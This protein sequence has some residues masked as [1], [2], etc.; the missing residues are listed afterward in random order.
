M[1]YIPGSHKFDQ[2]PHHDTFAKNNL[3]TRGQ[4]VMVEEDPS[5]RQIITLRPG[6]YESSAARVRL[7]HSCFEL[8]MEDQCWPRAPGWC[9]TYR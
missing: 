2:I 5:Q 6:S 4:E 7:F 8:A 1:E 9:L 3:L